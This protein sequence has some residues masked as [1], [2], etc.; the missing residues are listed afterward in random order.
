MKTNTQPD[1][2]EVTVKCAC[3]ASFKTGSTVKNIQVEICSECHPFFTGEM[4]FVD[5]MGRVERFQAKQKAA[6]KST[7]K[8]KKKDKTAE[9]DNQ[10]KTL[11]EMLTKNETEQSTKS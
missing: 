5:T 2:N 3:G 7:K 6:E 9:E 11:K 1:Y 8:S 10:P 4:K